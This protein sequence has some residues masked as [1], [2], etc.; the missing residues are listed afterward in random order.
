M[1]VSSNCVLGCTTGRM[2]QVGAR[3]LGRGLIKQWHR[4]VCVKMASTALIFS[5]LQP[6]RPA[7]HLPLRQQVVSGRVS[8]GNCSSL[9]LLRQCAST[10]PSYGA[11]NPVLLE[12]RE[13][14]DG[15]IMYKFGSPEQKEAMLTANEH[16]DSKDADGREELDNNPLNNSFSAD[17][18]QLQ[19][20]PGHHEEAVVSASSTSQLDA[21]VEQDSP[22]SDTNCGEIE[23]QFVDLELGEQQVDP[24]KNKDSSRKEVTV[25]NLDLK[26]SPQTIS[27][28]PTQVKGDET[29][30]LTSCRFS[31]GAAMIPH[32][33]KAAR[34]GED[35]Y[36]IEGSQWIGVA[37]GVG[38]WAL[39]GINAGHYARELMWHCAELARQS[40]KESDPKTLLVKSF[41]RTKAMGSTTAVVASISG[42][43]LTVVNMGDTGFLVVRDGEAV[44]R[45]TPMQRGFNF[46]YQIGS[47]GDDPF[48]AEVYRVPVEKGDVI[49][50]G[51]DGLFDN[52]FENQI[53]EIVD[54]LLQLKS[55]P[56]TVAKE[57]ANIAHKVGATQEGMS[58]F[59]KE[60][61]AVGYS[62]SGG[63][64]DD[65]TAVVSFVS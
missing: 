10:E 8:R 39:E 20:P 54:K 63:K 36:F 28:E 35:A 16:L 15:S 12:T 52:L 37:D 22:T 4:D 30:D 61:Q 48:L 5:A 40:D 62:Y 34:G 49:I 42:Q 3:A 64:M 31:S 25:D 7:L 23:Q 43:T 47:V 44:A 19:N 29:K 6:V 24:V 27:E 56:E 14:A 51:S 50:L 11:A 58:P 41:S 33:E 60:A 2:A 46:P 1:Q 9:L 55:E 45:S 65:I 17:A 18:E 57:L 59:A 38:G 53:V 21:V 13:C 32:P 26:T